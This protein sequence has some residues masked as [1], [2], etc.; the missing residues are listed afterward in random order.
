MSPIRAYMKQAKKMRRI[1]R[2]EETALARQYRKGNKRSGQKIIEA[3]LLF[4]VREANKWH[5]RW[6]LPLED[7]VQV[8]NE[9]MLRALQGFD[10][11][12]GVRFLSYASYWTRTWLDRY[13]MRNSGMVNF[14]TTIM[15]RRLFF[16][17]RAVVDRMKHQH[18]HAELAELLAMAAAEL[19]AGVKEVEAAYR[20]G[21][22]QSLNEPVGNERQTGKKAEHQ[23]F[24]ASCTT[25][26]DDLLAEAQ[27]AAVVAS[28]VR[29]N[30]RNGKEW[31]IAETRLLTDDPKTLTQIGEHCGISRER[32]RQLGAGLIE[33]A[34][35]DI[36]A[37]GVA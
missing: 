31:A 8:A 15:R 32:V 27:T 34:K 22:D 23:D 14:G 18:P 13:V 21:S 25:R 16:M 1:N 12:R 17:A 19:G 5:R 29:R 30:I 36:L 6:R 33:R 24:V 11:E 20:H 26:Q 9:G 37:A 4:A 35:E 7:L 28:A 10:P 2:E 3:H